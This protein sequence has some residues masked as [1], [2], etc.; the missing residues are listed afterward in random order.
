[1]ATTE[2]ACES[3]WE[4]SA[5][6][7]ESVRTW[8]AWR[9]SALPHPLK[10]RES[11]RTMTSDSQ[12]PNHLTAVDER[13]A[14]KVVVVKV[15]QFDVRVEPVFARKDPVLPAWIPFS[16]FHWSV[17]E[18]EDTW[19]R[20]KEVFSRYDYKFAAIRLNGL[21]FS[22]SQAILTRR[23]QIMPRGKKNIL[24]SSTPKERQYSP[25]SSIST[26]VLDYGRIKFLRC[27][28]SLLEDVRFKERIFVKNWGNFDD[29][30]DK[31]I[32]QWIL[33]KIV[34]TIMQP[35]LTWNEPY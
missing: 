6:N 13:K 25:P 22:C 3:A 35:E 2:R 28:E 31:S 27:N 10:Q 11:T 24:P 7:V 26:K 4:S 20:E 32:V 8:H 21:T 23:G 34:E 1:M 29:L 17:K 33:C 5:H 15:M 30:R 9:A 16:P 14:C 12:H 18:T 19:F